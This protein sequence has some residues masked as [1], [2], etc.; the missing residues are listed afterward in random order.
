MYT[1]LKSNDKFDNEISFLERVPGTQNWFRRVILK[2]GKDIKNATS[3][4]FT[5]TS[6]YVDLNYHTETGA[7]TGIVYKNIQ[8]ESELNNPKVLQSKKTEYSVLDFA[9]NNKSKYVLSS[10][11]YDEVKNKK[12]TGKKLLAFNNHVVSIE[13]Y[14]NGKTWKNLRWIDEDVYESSK[15]AKFSGT[16]VGNPIQLKHQKDPKLNGRILLPMYQI[17]GGGIP[18]YYLY[19]DD[20]GNSW[21]RQNVSFPRNLTESS[22]IEAKDGSIYWLLRNDRGFG[23]ATAK[24]WITKSVDGGKT[25]IN[26]NG[27]TGSNGKDLNIGNK[28]FDGNVFSGIGYFNLKGKDYFIFSIAKDNIRR[29]G[30]LFITDSTFNDATEL[31]DYDFMLN[32]GNKNEHFVYS[33]ALTIDEEKDYVDI[34]SIYEASEKTRVHGDSHG[35]G[36]S[37]WEKHR[38]QADEIQVDRFRIWL[39]DQK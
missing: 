3:S 31:F 12:K 39:K 29:N 33:Y 1:R 23:A 38:P 8:S 17:G 19:S 21:K 15:N 20:Y 18:A 16:A 2:D 14:D 37:E 28:N 26:P 9:N 13:S 5:L 7:I 27:D 22:M 30:S 25:W 10:D 32:Q 36:L 6:D 11:E 24:H 35:K 34:L 4:D